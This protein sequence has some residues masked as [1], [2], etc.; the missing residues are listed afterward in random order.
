[1]ET[2]TYKVIANL[3]LCTPREDVFKAVNSLDT[4]INNLCNYPFFSLMEKLLRTKHP[5]MICGHF[6]SIRV[7]LFKDH[8]VQRFYQIPIAYNRMYAPLFYKLCIQ[9]EQNNKKQRQ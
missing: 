4:S 2:R 6:E 9:Q 5:T 7:Y 3:S 8:I 1:M